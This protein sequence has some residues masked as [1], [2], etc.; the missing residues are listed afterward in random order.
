[1]S[2]F[3][4]D[5]QYEI[6]EGDEAWAR[7]GDNYELDCHITAPPD[8]ELYE[9]A[10]DTATIEPDTHQ[11][12]L[13]AD[14]ANE[15]TP[16][17]DLAVRL[18]QLLAQ[19]AKEYGVTIPQVMAIRAGKILSGERVVDPKHRRTPGSRGSGV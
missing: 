8:E 3:E 2:L 5:G 6:P 10:D 15:M 7:D 17:S 14:T 1:M 18:G 16:P 19:N 9:A 4:T 12:V 13:A 11:E